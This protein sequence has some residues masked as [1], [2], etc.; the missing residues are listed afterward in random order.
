MDEDGLGLG[1]TTSPPGPGEHHSSR[2]LL[3]SLASDLYV[4]ENGRRTMTGR[5]SWTRSLDPGV[6]P[7]GA[8]GANGLG[9][10]CSFGEAELVAASDWARRPLRSM[11]WCRPSGA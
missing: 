9:Q 8:N 5:A 6:N 11:R 3:V 4:R 2:G 10:A 1:S 7:L